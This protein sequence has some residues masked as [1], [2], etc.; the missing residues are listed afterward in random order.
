MHAMAT[1]DKG[2]GRSI[3]R[4]IDFSIEDTEAT[5]LDHDNESTSGSDTTIALGGQEAEG[6]PND[7]IHITRTG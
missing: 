2:T 7:F 5:N 1:H 6:H 3:D 4:D